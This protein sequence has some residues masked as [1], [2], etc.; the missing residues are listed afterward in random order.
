MLK[1]TWEI[2]KYSKQTDKNNTNTITSTAL[3]GKKWHS[4]P[5][6]VDLLIDLLN[7][8]SYLW[9]NHKYQTDQMF[10]SMSMTENNCNTG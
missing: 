1:I 7:V 9:V 2:V 10:T 3:V 4:R 6:H 8:G 5:V